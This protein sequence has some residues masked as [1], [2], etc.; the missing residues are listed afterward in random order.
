MHRFSVDSHVESDHGPVSKRARSDT[1]V[2]Q[3]GE[4]IGGDETTEVI[5]ARTR[6]A[7]ACEKCRSRKTK[8]DNRRPACGYCSKHRIHCVYDG[9]AS[10]SA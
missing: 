1:A 7:S 3:S 6:G 10:S 9:D 2:N 8:C 4:T 5:V